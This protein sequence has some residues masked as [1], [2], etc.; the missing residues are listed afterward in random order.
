M[1]KASI[2]LK[3]NGVSRRVEVAAN[4]TLLEVL[5]EKLGVKTAKIGCDRGDCGTCTVLMDGRTVR[6]CLVLAMEA[7]GTRIE[8]VEGLSK[9]GGTPLQKA[10][11][12]RN[13]FQCGFC[14]PGVT[15]SATELLRRN[16]RPSRH[17]IQEAIGGNLCRCT[18]YL[19]IIE[20]IEDAAGGKD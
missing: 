4:D 16:P 11:V 2:T 13:S 3:L 12:K 9:N 1:R 6:A 14:A 18:G 7:E 20:A 15:L 8:T 5:R 10:F 17:E 19:P